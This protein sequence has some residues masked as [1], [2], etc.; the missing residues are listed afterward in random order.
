[1]SMIPKA[2]FY[3][4][5]FVAQPGVRSIRQASKESRGH[6][7]EMGKESKDHGDGE[8]SEHQRD[9]GEHPRIR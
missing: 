4:R 9:D 5:C 6:D 2:R 8:T 3:S 1:M 7:L